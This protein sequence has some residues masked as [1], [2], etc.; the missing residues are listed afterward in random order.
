MSFLITFFEDNNC[1]LN[2]R[3]LWSP[4]SLLVIVDATLC[5]NQFIGSLRSLITLLAFSACILLKPFHA[6]PSQQRRRSQRMNNAMAI[7]GFA[8]ILFDTFFAQV[9]S[10]SAVLI[11]S[12]RF[13]AICWPLKH[14][15]LSMRVY[16]IDTFITWAV[17][18]LVS[19]IFTVLFRMMS[20]RDA[21]YVW[22]PYAVTV[23]LIICGCT[24]GIW[25]GSAK[26]FCFGTK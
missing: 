18:F 4:L 16:K 25:K 8:F 12:E 21:Y 19:A 6:E 20:A 17:A 11:P 9:S 2:C 14:R 13:H 22:M 5:S 1:S 26:S 3:P 24:L 7:T 23:L 10:I 15:A